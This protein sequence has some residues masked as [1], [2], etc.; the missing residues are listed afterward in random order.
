M[1]PLKLQS[2]QPNLIELEKYI[3]Q[4]L[5]EIKIITVPHSLMILCFRTVK[6]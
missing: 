6:A 2:V 1:K 5:I 4:K 3:I